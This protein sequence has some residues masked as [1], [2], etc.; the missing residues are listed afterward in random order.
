MIN[1]R[2]LKQDYS[3]AVIKEG[4]T[5]FEKGMVISSKIVSLKQSSVRLSCRVLGHFDNAYQ[6]DI[7]I[8]RKQSTTI[9]SD[10]DCSHKYDCQHLF[11]LL[12]L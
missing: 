1:F 4:R 6:C 11:L 9:D 10:C 3:P 5:I 8:D 2:K 7:E 12:Q